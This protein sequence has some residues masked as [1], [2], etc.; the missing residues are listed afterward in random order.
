MTKAIDL[1][2]I[3]RKAW[4]SF[5]QDGLWDIYLGLLL[6]ALGVNAYIS[7]YAGVSEGTSL[8]I[9]V[10]LEIGAML[11]LWVGKRFITA[12]RI[13]RATFGK[14][15]KRRL[16]I[17]RLLLGLS[18]LFGLLMFVVA[19]MAMEQ[20][21]AWLVPEIVFP[22]AWSI[23]AL[24]LFSLGAYFLEFK[25]LYLHGVLFA[26][27]VPVDFYLMVVHDIKIA[28]W[29][30]GIA[31]LIGVVVG[32]VVFFRFLRDYPPIRVGGEEAINEGH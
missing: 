5:F 1:K 9:L 18:V 28:Y 27:P 32:L 14:K 11:V 30:F 25:R 20:P 7:T 10:G 29:A 26:L 2:A 6:I 19:V 31:G 15:R 16:T 23:N 13:G 12:P 22:A 24:V 21:P 8:L 4:R 17:V 3:E